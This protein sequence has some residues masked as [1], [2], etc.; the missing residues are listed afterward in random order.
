MFYLELSEKKKPLQWDFVLKIELIK[1][2]KIMKNMMCIKL[3]I[4]LHDMDID[5]FKDTR[6][7]YGMKE[8]WEWDITFKYGIP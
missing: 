4:Q 6:I 3:I 1:K 8:S 7:T 5:V 2:I